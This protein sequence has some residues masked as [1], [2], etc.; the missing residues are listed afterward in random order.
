[1]RKQVSKL[2]TAVYHA[3]VQNKNVPYSTTTN[4]ATW[5]NSVEIAIENIG[6]WL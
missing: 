4:L 3:K 1:M 2:E 5:Q 6:F